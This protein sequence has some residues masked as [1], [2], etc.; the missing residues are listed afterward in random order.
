MFYQWATS[1]IFIYTTY[2]E[3]ILRAHFHHNE[4]P[5]NRPPNHTAQWHRL[6]APKMWAKWI[7]S[8][9]KPLTQVLIKMKE[10]MIDTETSLLKATVQLFFYAE[11]RPKTIL[12]S[13]AMIW[14]K[15]FDASVAM[16]SE[17][18]C[19]GALSLST[20]HNL[21]LPERKVTMKYSPH[22]INFV[23]FPQM[24]RCKTF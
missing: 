17:G 10:N 14:T 20:W 16:F 6:K 7:L 15:S 13:K 3:I 8:L 24:W 1:D 18:L 21:E 4:I 2:K 12:P 19:D 23:L 5:H 22:R 9:H 11:I